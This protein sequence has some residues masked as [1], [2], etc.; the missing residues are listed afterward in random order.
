MKR[1]APLVTALLLVTALSLRAQGPDNGELR[2]ALLRDL[3]LPG[4]PLTAIIAGFPGPPPE[5]E[6]RAVLVAG[7][8]RLAAAKFFS[9]DG[10]EGGLPCMAA[11][12]AVPSTARP[13]PAL[14]RIEAGSAAAGELALNIGERSFLTEEIPL[15]QANTDI[16]TKPDP[17]KT[18]EAAL[19]WSILSRTGKTIY[20]MGPFVPPVSSTRRTSFFGDRRV[21]IYTDGSRDRSIHA[22]VDYGVPTGTAVRACADGMVVL[23]HS[24]IVTG[25]SVVLEHLPG[26]YSLYYH[27]DRMAVSEGQI[28]KS[29]EM[30]G[31]S[32]STGLATGPHLHWEIRVSGENTDPDALVSHPVIDR[33]AI[34]GKIEL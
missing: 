4:E 28:V 24:R 16:R 18:E 7:G 23:A 2:F 32:G 30:L 27:L 25:N 11:V 13:G 14:V 12:L 31:N 29:G 20:S 3:V 21:F 1:P 22:G 8:S 26:V 34:L 6:F 19:L 9:L 15:D 5:G 33:E 10:E 17:R